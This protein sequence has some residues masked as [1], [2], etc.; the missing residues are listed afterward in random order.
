[1]L[2]ELIILVAV[3]VLVSISLIGFN[4]FFLKKKFPETHV[5]HNS[6]MK[7]LGITCA[8]HED[9]GKTRTDTRKID[10]EDIKIVSP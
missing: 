9:I 10:P 6:N 8:K 4:V 7:K 5:G 3:L 1:M 2:L